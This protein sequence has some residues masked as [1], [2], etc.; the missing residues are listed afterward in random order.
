MGVA[1]DLDHPNSLIGELTRIRLLQ[2][3]Q[4][5]ALLNARKYFP[6]LEPLWFSNAEVATDLS[7][8]MVFDLSVPRN[9]ASFVGDCVAPPRVAGTLAQ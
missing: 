8:E 4:K 5:S 6:E 7:R 3:P 9:C 2:C 1:S